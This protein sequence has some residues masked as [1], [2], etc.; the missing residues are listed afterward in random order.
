MTP[1]LYLPEFRDF[2]YLQGSHT[3]IEW[4]KRNKSQIDKVR[5]PGQEDNTMFSWRS[6]IEFIEQI[7]DHRDSEIFIVEPGDIVKDFDI[8]RETTHYRYEDGR[9]SCLQNPVIYEGHPVNPF[10]GREIT[11][12]D[13]RII[14]DDPK[15]EA[16][17]FLCSAAW[18]EEDRDVTAQ[19]TRIFNL[20]RISLIPTVFYRY[21]A[22]FFNRAEAELYCDAI[23][24]Y[25]RKNHDTISAMLNMP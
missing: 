4:I 19:G 23:M 25:M 5:P 22:I 7:M 13:I 20:N 3:F 6:R 8:I 15:V 17:F 21:T 10:T 18:F 2:K 1:E 11:R 24:D 14:E 16:R 9:V 12:D